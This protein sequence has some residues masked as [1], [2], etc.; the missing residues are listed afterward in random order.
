MAIGRG[1]L[2]RRQGRFTVLWQAL[3]SIRQFPTTLPMDRSRGSVGLASAQDHANKNTP[4]ATLPLNCLTLACTHG[5]GRWLSRTSVIQ[6]Q[7]R[8]PDLA[9]FG[10]ITPPDYES[11]SETG[12]CSALRREYYSLRPPCCTQTSARDSA[13]APSSSLQIFPPTQC[14]KPLRSRE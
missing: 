1:L 13:R 11:G 14:R 12:F 10:T 6:R 3:G 9:R 4:F 7:Y 5:R 8:R 2:R